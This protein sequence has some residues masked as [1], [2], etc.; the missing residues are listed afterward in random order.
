MNKTNK[1][2]TSV[3]G[4]MDLMKQMMFCCIYSSMLGKS[5]PYGESIFILN[6]FSFSVLLFIKEPE[7]EEDDDDVE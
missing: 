6:Y 2:G 1:K 4:W 5:F 3:K 7:E